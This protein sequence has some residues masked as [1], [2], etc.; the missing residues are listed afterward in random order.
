MMWNPSELSLASPP[1][2]PLQTVRCLTVLSYGVYSYA[3]VG[4]AKLDMWQ[5]HDFGIDI[6]NGAVMY[7]VDMLLQDGTGRREGLPHQ[8]TTFCHSGVCA[9][10][11]FCLI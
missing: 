11:W 4:A 10:G 6:E 1:A 2:V 7:L 9:I 8:D 5:Q 3:W